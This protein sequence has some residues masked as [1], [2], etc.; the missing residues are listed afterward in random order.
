MLRSLPHPIQVRFRPVV[1]FFLIVL[2]QSLTETVNRPEG[3]PEIMGNG[4]AKSLQLP[5]G[6]VKLGST[7]TDTPL[8]FGIEFVNL[9]FNLFAFGNIL[10]GEYN[11]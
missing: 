5:V 3:R 11:I 1:E 6:C 10:S 2:K 4:I 9:L 7:V 8:Q